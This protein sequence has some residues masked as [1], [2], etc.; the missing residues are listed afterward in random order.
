[1]S[2]GFGRINT[3]FWS[4]RRKDRNRNFFRFFGGLNRGEISSFSVMFGKTVNAVSGVIIYTGFDLFCSS[5]PIF[6][7]YG[8]RGLWA[9]RSLLGVDCA[10]RCGWLLLTSISTCSLGLLEWSPVLGQS[11]NNC[12]WNLYVCWD[13]WIAILALNLACGMDY[14]IGTRWFILLVVLLE[15]FM[16]CIGG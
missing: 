1:M 10:F 13:I 6:E 2:I 12:G 8:N 4:T 3:C 16:T 7:V 15:D 9:A 5:S 14:Y 11:I